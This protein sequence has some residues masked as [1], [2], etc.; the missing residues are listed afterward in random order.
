MIIKR[1]K[2][3]NWRNFQSVDVE[4]KDRVFLIGPNA[5]GKSNFLDVF[6]FLR[7]I[8]KSNGGLEQAVKDR[9][10]IP[11]IRYLPARREQDIEIE[12]YILDKK[13]SIN[14]KY[15]IGIRQ[16]KSVNRKAFL[17]YEKV[18]RNDE[19]LLSRPDSADKVDPLRLTQTHLEQTYANFEFRKIAG[20]FESIVYFHLIPQVIKYS[21]NFSKPN[22]KGDPFG[23]NFLESIAET[24]SKIRDSRLKRIEKALQKV[25]PQLKDLQRVQDEYGYTHLGITYEHWRPNAG[26][27]T[28][29]ELSDGTL[30]LIA[31]L[32][33]VLDGDSL[34]LLEEPE[35]SLHISI[36]RLIPDLISKIQI[37]MKKSRQI[38]ISTHSPELLSSKGISGEEVLLLKP[39]ENGTNIETANSREDVRVLIEEG[40][41][42]GE[43]A[44]P[45][46][47]PSNIEQL[48]L[49]ND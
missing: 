34:L 47:K 29:E 11:K 19:E 46:T 14:W 17:V 16:E 20:F 8:A 25:V 12:V 4:L 39:D 2:L 26:K 44:F 7:D 21:D 40:V 35:L 5:S 48:L 32:W 30:R 33:S 6:R 28:E 49:F 3:K 22:L 31:L 23:R 18:F 41:P 36:V 24:N 45:K 13:E 27:Q 15:A 10:G 43:A 37:E 38:I 1:V 42:V 9:G